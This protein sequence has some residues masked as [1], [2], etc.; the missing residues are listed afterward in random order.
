MLDLHHLPYQ[1]SFL[2]DYRPGI[3]LIG[4][5][6]IVRSAHLPTY[7]KHHL[8]MVGAFDPQGFCPASTTVDHGWPAIDCQEVTETSEVRSGAGDGNRTHGPMQQ[9]LLGSKRVLRLRS[10]YSKRN[11]LVPDCSPTALRTS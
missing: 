6:N 9:R 4:C 2:P 3:G 7:Q 11:R 8:N 5:G 10:D 1:P